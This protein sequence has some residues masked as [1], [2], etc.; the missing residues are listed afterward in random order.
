MENEHVYKTVEIVGSS[1]N[2]IQPA[3][4]RAVARAAET[5]HNLRWMEVVDLRGHLEG[6]RVSHWQVTVKLG[7]RLDDPTGE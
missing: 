2:G 4:E 3:I 1:P 7:F 5:V 6:N